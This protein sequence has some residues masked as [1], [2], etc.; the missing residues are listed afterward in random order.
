[1]FAGNTVVIG[2]GGILDNSSATLALDANTTGSLTINGGTL[3][4]G[5]VTGAHGAKVIVN[6][7]TLDGATINCEL[8]LSGSVTIVDGLTLNATAQVS[9]YSLTFSNTETLTGTGTMVFNDTTVYLNYSNTLTIDTGITLTGSAS[10]YGS[11][12]YYYGNNSAAIVNKGTITADNA[13]AYFSVG[14]F[15]NSGTLQSKNTGSIDVQATTFTNSGSLSAQSGGLTTITGMSGSLGTV[16]VTGGSSLSITGA[17]YTVSA[18]TIGSSADTGN[19][20]S[21]LGSW[22]ATGNLSAT[23]ATLSLG[24]AGVSSSIWSS[25]STIVVTNCTVNLGGA[26]TTLPLITN[27]KNTINVVGSFTG[28]QFG[29]LFA[30]GNTVTLGDGAVITNTGND[31]Q[32]NAISGSLLMTGGEILNGSVTST[33]AGAQIVVTGSA[34]FDGLLLITNV[35]L[36]GGSL[37]I[38]HGLTLKNGTIQANDA[39]FNFNGNQTIDGASSAFPGQIVFGPA[40]TDVSINGTLTIGPNFSFHGGSAADSDGTG[41]IINNGAIDAD[42]PGGITL[43]VASFSN[44]GHLNVSNG[45]GLTITGVTGHL[46]AVTLSADPHNALSIAGTNYTVDA[47]LNAGATQSL[48]LLGSWTAGA[49]AAL[50]ANAGSTLALGTPGDATKVWTANSVTV[51][52]ATLNLGGS[53]ASVP[54][55]VAV[56]GSTIN[57]TGGYT[58]AQISGY[59]GATPA[60]TVTLTSQGTLDNSANIGANPL[61]LGTASSLNVIGGTIKGGVVQEANGF[62]LAPTGNLTLDNLTFNGSLNIS[63]NSLY[64]RDGL[65]FNG[66]ANFS[67]ASIYFN[68][69]QALQGDGTF[70]FDNTYNTLQPDYGTTL[71]IGP[72]FELHGSQLNIYGGAVNNQ[73]TIAADSP[74]DFLFN[75]STFTNNG[76]N[77]EAING[78][79]LN[80]QNFSGALSNVTASG[81]NSTLTVTGNNYTVSGAL[82]ATSGATLALYGPWSTSA[83]VS[84]SANAATL[85]LGTVGTSDAWK[86]GA[87]VLSNNAAVNLGGSPVSLAGLVAPAGSTIGIVSAFTTAQIQS[88]L[89]GNMLAIGPGGVLDNS[90]NA[91]RLAGPINLGGTLKGGSVNGNVVM[92][93]NGATLDGVVING[94]LDLTNDGATVRDGLTL[95]GTATLKG[96]TLTF[97]GSQTLGAASNGSAIIDLGANVNSQIYVAYSTTLTIGANVTIQGAGSIVGSNSIGAAE[98]IPG[99]VNSYASAL[100]NQG[101]FN[102]NISGAGLSINVDSVQNSGTLKASGGGVLNVSGISGN[103]GAATIAGAGSGLVFSGSNYVVNASFDLTGQQSLTLLG[104]WVLP[105]ANHITA[106]DSTLALG[107]PGDSTQTWSA[108][109]PITA[110]DGATVTIGGATTTL[111]TLAN[112]T[113]STLT[114]AGSFKYSAIATLLAANTGNA[115]DHRRRRLARSGRP[116]AHAQWRG[117]FPGPRWRHHQE[118]HDRRDRR[119]RCR[120]RRSRHA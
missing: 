42:A 116:N 72:N 20:L 75:G 97:Q 107:S 95:N 50:T 58:Y 104:T 67:N 48:G 109:G 69:S 56:T 82:T 14:T 63:D 17:N 3:K 24:T 27:G 102:A 13:Y 76:G 5:A 83:G 64:V 41:S 114:I 54:A 96:T 115:A 62:V 86:A 23:S 108:S 100:V 119:R 32:L 77:L 52:N 105:A 22:T 101:T 106:D 92:T 6:G 37:T 84:L 66:T 2:S 15:T 110:S 117:P 45:G 35:A 113:N 44:A 85:D 36:N 71:T 25:S 89:A 93:G 103:V 12:Y 91:T 55:N 65:T 47:P 31:L 7:G 61:H 29:G 10:F 46:G 51:T 57:I 73:G 60:N 16:S 18:L 80:I 87:I 90:A 11:A 19:A 81:A 59:L 118:R 120:H 38:Q 94:N 70:A 34:T 33:V 74:G 68:G 28:A 40:N 111:A 21:L 79:T 26:S 88:F 43:D 30:V 8:D 98:N 78:G 9:T 99:A 49:N 53:S 1:M 112:S 4:N 39:S